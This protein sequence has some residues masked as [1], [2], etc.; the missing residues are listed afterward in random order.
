M[1]F[2]C[3][4]QMEKTHKFDIIWNESLLLNY[5]Q[6][7]DVQI[8]NLLSVYRNNANRRFQINQAFTVANDNATTLS[9]NQFVNVCSEE[10]I[11]QNK[12]NKKSNTQ[13]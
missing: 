5:T 4:W 9:K 11:K 1:L 10:N 7:E 13:S 12:K 3:V 6:G 8:N 2:N